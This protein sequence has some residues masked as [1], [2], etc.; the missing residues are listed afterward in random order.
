MF[1]PDSDLHNIASKLCA[2]LR[3]LNLNGCIS[4]TDAGISFVLLKCVLLHSVFLCDTYFGQRSVLALCSG[5]RNFEDLVEPQV[6]KPLQSLAYKLHTLHI[7]GCMGK[8]C[9]LFLL[10]WLIFFHRKV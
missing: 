8:W 6:E 7:G 1:S 3:Y 5:V 10:C 4:V 2:S 9:D